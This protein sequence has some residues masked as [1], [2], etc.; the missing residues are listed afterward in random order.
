MRERTKAAFDDIL[1]TMGGADGGLRFASYM[2]LIRSL[3]DQAAAGDVASE[4]LLEV[5]F[6]FKKLIDVAEKVRKGEY[7]K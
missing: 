7:R 3:D 1:D 6:R 5:M 4:A 2:M